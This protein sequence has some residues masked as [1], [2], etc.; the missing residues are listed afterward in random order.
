ME[1]LQ[2]MA[3]PPTCDDDLPVWSEPGDDGWSDVRFLAMAKNGSKGEAYGYLLANLGRLRGY[4]RA[5]FPAELGGDQGIEELL[6]EVAWK[7]VEG[8]ESYRPMRGG[9][10]VWVFK[11]GA[12]RAIDVVRAE[13]SRR[14]REAAVARGKAVSVDEFAQRVLDAIHSLGPPYRDVLLFDLEHG[15]TAPAEVLAAHFEVT[16]QTVY[17]WRSKA[18]R[19]LFRSLQ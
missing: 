17:N 7:A 19:Q 10:R 3:P 14:S 18:R 4:L 12:N 5:R 8:V 16:K 15:G 1:A 6:H 9:A 11:M 13:A 2:S